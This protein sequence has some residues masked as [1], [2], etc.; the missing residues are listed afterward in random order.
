MA[1]NE[2]DHLTGEIVKL[3]EVS[4]LIGA[5]RSGTL[6][7]VL[8]KLRPGVLV[9]GC[10]SECGCRG[11]MC[12]CNGVVSARERFTD[13]SFP[14]FLEMRDQRIKELKREL[15]SLDVPKRISEVD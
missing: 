10:D 3:N 11:G 14:E 1:D 13:I 7:A 2:N 5:L 4:D 12:G 15:A 8:A 9:A 6:R